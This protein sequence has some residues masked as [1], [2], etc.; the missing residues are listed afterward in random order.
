MG[1]RKRRKS[2]HHEEFARQVTAVVDAAVHGYELFHARLVLDARIVQRRVQ[3]DDG[4][5]EHVTGVRVGEYVR[6]QLAVPLREALHHTV[7]FLRLAGQPE[8]PE[9]L[10]E[11]LHQDQVREVVQLDERAQHPL[12]EVVTLAEVIADR[13]FVQALALVQELG[14][15]LRRRC[16]QIVLDQVLDALLRVHVELLTADRRLLRL[17]RRL[18]LVGRQ[19]A[20]LHRL[21]LGHHLAQLIFQLLKTE[22]TPPGQGKEE[23]SALRFFFLFFFFKQTQ[24]AS[25]L[26]APRESPS[27]CARDRPDS[28]MSNTRSI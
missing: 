19:A 6:V 2:T 14:D 17:V 7:D 28:P 22:E 4:E 20:A 24:M 23:K 18:G 12:V 27:I 15:V 8:R 5:A 3:H 21:H 16:Q 25:P 1:E 10:P 13:R 9:E 11:R 26:F